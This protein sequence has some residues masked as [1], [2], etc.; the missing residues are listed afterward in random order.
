MHCCCSELLLCF[1]GKVI[2]DVVIISCAE[3]APLLCRT[4]GKKET[5]PW[6]LAEPSGRALWLREPCSLFN[7][8]HLNRRENSVWPVVWGGRPA[9]GIWA[10]AAGGGAKVE[11]LAKPG[12]VKVHAYTHKCIYTRPCGCRKICIIYT[13]VAHIMHIFAY[14][15][16]NALITL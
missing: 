9:A 8:F 12:V 6:F 2:V 4:R 15:N 10:K 14:K 16:A 11:E 5:C 3:V 1:C 13:L 7:L